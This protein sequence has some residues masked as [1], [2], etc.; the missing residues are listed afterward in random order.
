AVLGATGRYFS[1]ARW[2]AGRTQRSSPQPTNQSICRPAASRVPRLLRRPGRC[3][4]GLARRPRP[5]WLAS[6]PGRLPHNGA[7]AA[8]SRDRG[9]TACAIG[10]SFAAHIRPQ[11][12]EAFLLQ[13]LNLP[14]IFGRFVRAVLLA[15]GHD[16][17]GQ[18]LAHVGVRPQLIESG[19]VDIHQLR[20]E[21]GRYE[22]VLAQAV[23]EVGRCA[24]LR[25]GRLPAFAAKGVPKALF[26][27]A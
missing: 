20:G 18:R 14:Q 11:L 12:G 23:H 25:A 9:P 24:G 7:A 26:W 2:L 16:E 13:N 3:P 19:G 6:Q 21:A 22:R 17:A 8:R 1:G 10:R 27:A 4:P 5:R 15:K